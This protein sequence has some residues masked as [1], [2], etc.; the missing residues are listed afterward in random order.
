[1]SGLVKKAELLM[2]FIFL[3]QIGHGEQRK[4]CNFVIFILVVF[5]IFGSI[6]ERKCVVIENYMRN[7]SI[8]YFARD[9]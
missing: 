2:P 6:L 1:M 5:H 9:N 7:F 8:N 4:F 3:F